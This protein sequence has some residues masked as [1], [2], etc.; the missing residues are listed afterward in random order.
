MSVMLTSNERQVA[1]DAMDKSMDD[2][3]RQTVRLYAAVTARSSPELTKA[4]ALALAERLGSADSK[5]ATT[6]AERIRL[7]YEPPKPA[8]PTE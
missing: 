6:L 8:A 7:T 1:I 3:T 4:D 5:E 2:A